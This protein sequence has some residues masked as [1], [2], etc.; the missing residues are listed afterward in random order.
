MSIDD[1]EPDPDYVPK[2]F[3]PAERCQLTLFAHASDAEYDSRLIEIYADEY[4]VI[5]VTCERSEDH[6]LVAELL[7][8]ESG[9]VHTRIPLDILMGLLKRAENRLE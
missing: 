3:V 9:R 5:R 7:D 6:R 8:K 4:E 2:S 1:W